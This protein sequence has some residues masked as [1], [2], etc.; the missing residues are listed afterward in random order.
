MVELLKK[1][2]CKQCDCMAQLKSRIQFLVEMYVGSN[3]LII[4]LNISE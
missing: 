4:L 1:I 2:I 3:W